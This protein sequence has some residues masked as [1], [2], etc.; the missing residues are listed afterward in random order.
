M[1]N[2][3]VSE[4]VKMFI[5]HDQFG[6]I[7]IP[8]DNIETIKS[9]EPLRS[10]MTKIHFTKV[11]EKPRCKDESMVLDITLAMLMIDEHVHENNLGAVE[12]AKER[13][14]TNLDRYIIR[15]MQVDEILFESDGVRLYCTWLDCYDT[16]RLYYGHRCN[17]AASC[18]GKNDLYLHCHTPQFYF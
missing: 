5:V 13:G 16:R 4:N 11:G 6:R 9:T 15:D 14:Y 1:R 12:H 10:D 17:V 3:R 18:R 7:E 2:I 8:I